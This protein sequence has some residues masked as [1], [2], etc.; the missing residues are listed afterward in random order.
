[1][2][3]IT[4]N[5]ADSSKF[6]AKCGGRQQMN[7]R[8]DANYTACAPTMFLT[9]IRYRN[10]AHSY[11]PSPRLVKARPGWESANRRPATRYC[12]WMEFSENTGLSW[13]KPTVDGGSAGPVA[14][15]MS[16]VVAA[17]A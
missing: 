14:A 5:G 12:D 15:A 8:V 2:P 13:E 9:T 4:A 11:I 6:L 1:M 7:R 16:V 3:R 10:E 17:G